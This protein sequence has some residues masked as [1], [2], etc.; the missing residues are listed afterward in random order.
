M[1]LAANKIQVHE[2]AA[3]STVL[4][5]N[6]KEKRD[7]GGGFAFGL[8][9]QSRAHPTHLGLVRAAPLQRWGLCLAWSLPKPPA[10]L[11]IR[12][13]VCSTVLPPLCTPQTT[14]AFAT[15][16]GIISL[17]F[18]E[19]PLLQAAELGHPA[20]ASHPMASHP[21]DVCWA[22]SF[23]PQFS[24]PQGGDTRGRDAQQTI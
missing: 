17:L 12:L 24:V 18:L 14:L 8:Q 13:L 6:G 23:T 3:R 1:R 20:L 4:L 16:F 2:A 19:F 10:V 22:L 5:G 7:P 11:I 9:L 21:R 15:D